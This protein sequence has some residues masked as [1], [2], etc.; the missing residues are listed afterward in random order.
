MTLIVFGVQY[1]PW[2]ARLKCIIA[3]TMGVKHADFKKPLCICSDGSKRDIGGYLFQKGADDEERI[4]Q[5]ALKKTREAS[6]RKSPSSCDLPTYLPEHY[7]QL[8][9]G[10]GVVG[11]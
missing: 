7:Q 5:G 4:I 6:C 11:G 10:A 9:Q 1:T 3:I 8:P 2:L